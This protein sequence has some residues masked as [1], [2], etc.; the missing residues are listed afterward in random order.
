MH[1]CAQPCTTDSRKTPAKYKPV[2]YGH[3][4]NQTLQR[5]LCLRRFENKAIVNA[6]SINEYYQYLFELPVCTRTKFVPRGS[7]SDLSD[8]HL[9]R[10]RQN[11]PQDTHVTAPRPPCSTRLSVSSVFAPNSKHR[12]Q[13]T[14]ARRGKVKKIRSL[15]EDQ[16]PAERRAGLLP[17]SRAPPATGLFA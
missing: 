11:P 9:F 15:D 16:T 8:P 5:V 7:L 4:K 2:K 12:V 17:E 6:R 13:V 3:S 1:D 14:P 10:H